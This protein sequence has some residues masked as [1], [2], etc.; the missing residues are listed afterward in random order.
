M[1]RIHSPSVS[2]RGGKTM[3][4]PRAMRLAWMPLPIPMRKALSTSAG[5]SVM[6]AS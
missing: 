4:S 3:V 2:R 1:R 5:S 6:P